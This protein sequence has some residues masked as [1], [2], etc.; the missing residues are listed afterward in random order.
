[1]GLTCFGEARRKR[2]RLSADEQHRLREGTMGAFHNQC[3]RCGGPN[4]RSARTQ[5]VGDGAARTHYLHYFL[6][7]ALCALETEDDRLI[8]LNGAGMQT[9]ISLAGRR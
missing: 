4:E 1:M 5:H 3:A 7:C 6:K 9:A 8:A 2:R